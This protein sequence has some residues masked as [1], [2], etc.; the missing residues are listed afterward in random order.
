M[1]KILHSVLYNRLHNSRF[2]FMRSGLYLPISL[3]GPTRYGYPQRLKVV[4]FVGNS[5][6]FNQLNISRADIPCV[7]D[8]NV[9]G[10][11]RSTQPVTLYI[12]VTVAPPNLYNSSSSIPTKAED[13][14][15]VT[16]PEHVQFPV[17][18]H[19]LP[20]SHHQSIAAGNTI[21]AIPHS[22]EEKSPTGVESSR[23]PLHRADE[24]MKRIVPIDRSNT[25][26][27]A[28]VRIKWV[29]DMLGPI[30]EVRVMLFDVL[31]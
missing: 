30:A 28:V 11:A 19:V 16:I 1:A 23:F 27:G 21:P 10:A 26:E 3:S 15:A 12:S 7:L 20:L 5:F 18:E 9:G 24:A 25:W 31:G 8:N 29:M 22:L 13:S 17:A 2:V 4:R 6:S 14:P